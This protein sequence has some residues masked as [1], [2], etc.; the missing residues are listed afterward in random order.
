MCQPHFIVR[1]SARST[2]PSGKQMCQSAVHL[3]A[4]LHLLSN[5]SATLHCRSICSQLFTFC[6]ES[7][8]LFF[9]FCVELAETKLIPKLQG[10]RHVRARIQTPHRQRITSLSW[11]RTGSETSGTGALRQAEAAPGKNDPKSHIPLWRINITVYI[12]QGRNQIVPVLD[13]TL[14]LVS[15]LDWQ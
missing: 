12:V 8:T 9:V 13:K 3:L 11:E 10:R 4:P 6:Q 15:S 7:L 14:V 1:T 2:S 5:V